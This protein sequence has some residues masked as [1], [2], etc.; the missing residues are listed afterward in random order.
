MLFTN[1]LRL[2]AISFVAVVM[3]SPVQA[4]ETVSKDSTL[5]LR[6]TTE[7]GRWKHT[8]KN[9]KG[10]AMIYMDD[11][12]KAVNGYVIVA[13]RPNIVDYYKLSAEDWLLKQR[14]D[15]FLNGPYSEDS[16]NIKKGVPVVEDTLI[17][18]VAG[19]FF[20]YSVSINDNLRYVS[21]F[22]LDTGSVVYQG[23]FDSGETSVALQ[24]SELLKQMLAGIQF[25][26]P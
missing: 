20:H 15:S 21:F 23:R 8:M 16:K 26:L 11:N 1:V 5:P 6:V 7:G 4:A 18:G 17:D 12:Q 2:M 24:G 25:N 14:V 10:Y 13:L 3:A 9:G 19:K 22:I